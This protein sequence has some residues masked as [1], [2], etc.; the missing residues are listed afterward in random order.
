MGGHRAAV[1][2]HHVH[3]VGVRGVDDVGHLAVLEIASVRLA[4]VVREVEDAAVGLAQRRLVLHRE[5]RAPEVLDHDAALVDQV[6]LRL[7]AEEIAL[8]DVLQG[9]RW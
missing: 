2:R 9:S 7:D 5:W 4:E 1:P 3:L 8:R 6:L